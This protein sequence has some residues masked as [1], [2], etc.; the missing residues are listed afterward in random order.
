V[1]LRISCA[2][3]DM[4]KGTREQR[5]AGHIKLSCT[6]N[7]VRKGKR[8]KK[9][10]QGCYKLLLYTLTFCYTGVTLLLHYPYMQLYCSYTVVTLL[11]HEKAR[12]SAFAHPLESTVVINCCHMLLKCCCWCYTVV[13]HSYT[14]VALL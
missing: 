10:A 9:C 11:L 3:S 13:T 7:D 2:Y 6:C 1:N 5:G 4:R 12:V 8:E 14:V